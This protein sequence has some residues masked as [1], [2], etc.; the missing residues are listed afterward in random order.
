MRSAESIDGD[1]T[2]DNTTI[3]LRLCL[4]SHQAANDGYEPSK[5]AFVWTCV[6]CRSTDG[7]YQGRVSVPLT[8]VLFPANT[9]SRTSADIQPAD[10]K[11]PVLSHGD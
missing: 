9:S 11:V 1:P 5:N 4:P 2:T 6:G 10:C 3:S 7:A 8:L